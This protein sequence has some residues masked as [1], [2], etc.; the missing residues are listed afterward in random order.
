[1][2]EPVESIKRQWVVDTFQRLFS[3]PTPLKPNV[4]ILVD[5]KKILTEDEIRILIKQIAKILGGC[6]IPSSHNLNAAVVSVREGRGVGMG[7]P[8][9][10]STRAISRI[11]KK[12]NEAQ[13]QIDKN[14]VG[15]IWI[16]LNWEEDVHSQVNEIINAFKDKEYSHIAAVIFCEYEHWKCDESSLYI[17]PNCVA[18]SLTV[19]Q[20]I[21]GIQKLL[22]TPWTIRYDWTNTRICP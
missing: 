20:I 6:A 18:D 14:G 11:S 22:S 3:E 13:N 10:D 16:K 17:N 1:M 4:A 7:F 21:K 8:F 5:F 15:I 19:E 12:F 2:Q 9:F